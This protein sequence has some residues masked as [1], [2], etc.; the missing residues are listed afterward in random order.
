MAGKN[1]AKGK[2]AG[3]VA[4]AEEEAVSTAPVADAAS[5]ESSESSEAKPKEKVAA[6]SRPSKPEGSIKVTLP[7]GTF[8][9]YSKKTHGAVYKTLA[10]NYAESHDGKIS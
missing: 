7:D 8:R 1:S 9:L 6:T 2:T 4:G 5:S 3:K 10:E